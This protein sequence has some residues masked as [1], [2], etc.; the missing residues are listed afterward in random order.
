MSRSTT[1]GGKP[2][3]VVLPIRERNGENHS[4]DQ[5]ESAVQF[6][7]Y[8][9]PLCGRPLRGRDKLVLINA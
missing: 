4:A 5:A 6:A 8:T 3:G 2:P 9:R 1:P 7:H